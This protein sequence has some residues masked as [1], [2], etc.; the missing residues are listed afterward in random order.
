MGHTADERVEGRLVERVGDRAH[1]AADGTPWEPGVGIERDHVAHV[2]RRRRCRSSRH[3]DPGRRRTAQDGVQLVELAALALPAHPAA[4]GLVPLSAAVE[5][6]EPG[7]TARGLAVALVE[8]V[9]RR[10]SGREQPVV[11]GDVLGG[12]VQPVREQGKPEVALAV[13]QVVHFEAAHLCLDIRLARQE[14]GDD[15]QCSQLGWDAAVEIEPRQGSRAEHVGDCPVDERDGKVGRRAEAEDRDE[16]DPRAG[17]GADPGQKEGDGKD[18]GG[19]DRDRAEV[20]GE[21]GPH[22]GPSQPHVDRHANLELALE[23]G[24]AIRD[25]VIAGI[26][27]AGRARR[28]GIAGSP[29]RVGIAGSPRRVRGCCGPSRDLN[30]GQPGA[31]GQVLDGMP[32]AISGGEVHVPER[33][34]LAE[35][36]VD[37][38]DALD[39]GGPVEPR[40]EPHARDHVADRH[41]HRR[42]ALVLQANRLLGRGPLARQELLQPA[43]RG[44]DGRILVP[45][46]LEQLHPGRRREARS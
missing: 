46:A 33:A 43:E 31:P 1:E 19:D 38:A 24:A 20:A 4:L 7:A 29:R 25:Q 18:E 23:G 37:Q 14:R 44:G 10:P 13:S 6:Q 28:V 16:Q 45:Q 9:D 15:D 32:V 8:T 11:A 5:Q 42:L 17:S 35:S 3:Q 39:E 41:V 22:V 12:G 27:V 40:D 26:L 30:L 34:A 2:R 36:F 21:P